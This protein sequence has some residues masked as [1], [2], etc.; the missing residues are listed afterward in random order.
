MEYFFSISKFDSIINKKKIKILNLKKCIIII[1]R[2]NN[3]S[4]FYSLFDPIKLKK[5]Y[6]LPKLYLK[7]SLNKKFF[8]LKNK[9]F[10]LLKKLIFTNK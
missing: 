5:N 8:E 1:I 7:D 10:N 3:K 4:F 2:I 9:Y 6:D